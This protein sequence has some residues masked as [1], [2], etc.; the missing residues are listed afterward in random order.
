M[1]IK[2]IRIRSFRCIRDATLPCEQLTA[3]V[4]PNGSGKSSFLRALALFYDVSARYTEEDFYAGDTGQDILITITFSDLTEEENKLFRK[5]VEGGELTV[6]K[7][8]KWPPVR[9][10]QKYY[11]TSLQNPEFDTF[12]LASSVKERKD[13]YEALRAL[14]EYA[15]LPKWTKQ[16]DGVET[17]KNW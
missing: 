14:E 12:R 16:D 5:Y 4:G 6:E 8:L 17:L 3:L 15:T 1:I 9:G 11:G 7:V 2:S 10:S 13:A